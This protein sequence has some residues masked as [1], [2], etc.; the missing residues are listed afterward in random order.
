[1]RR[2]ITPLELL[3]GDPEQYETVKRLVAGLP[4]GERLIARTFRNFKAMQRNIEVFRTLVAKKFA[5]ESEGDQFGTLLAGAW[6]LQHNGEAS[7]TRAREYFE[8]LVWTDCAPDKDDQDES[9]IVLRLLGHVVGLARQTGNRLD[10]TIG[11]LIHLFML[12][13]ADSDGLDPSEAFNQL[14][15]LG[16][17]CSEDGRWVHVAERGEELTKVFEGTQWEKNWRSPLERLPKALRGMASFAQRSQKA[18]A[19]P[20]ESLFLP[21]Q[22]KEEESNG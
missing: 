11:D 13:K 15:R 16:I 22:E 7:L 10:R 4:R 21:D 6:S 12:N 20:V 18:V 3:K 9:Q 1:V 5:S 14:L 17:R 8:K 2:R 19:I